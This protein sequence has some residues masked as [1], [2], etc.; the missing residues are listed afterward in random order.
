ML[1]NGPN[2][3]TAFR[4]VFDLFHSLDEDDRSDLYPILDMIG[5]ACCTADDSDMPHNTLSTQHT[6]RWVTEAWGRHLEPVEQAPSD[7]EDHLTS[8]DLAQPI[9][10]RQ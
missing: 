1:I 10:Y 6:K 3:G 8:A 7:Q 4:R 9:Q 5:M 2:F